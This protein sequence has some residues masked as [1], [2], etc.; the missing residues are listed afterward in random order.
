MSKT[1]EDGHPQHPVPMEALSA[2][3]QSVM[4]GNGGDISSCVHGIVVIV[5]NKCKGIF[6]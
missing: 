4:D 3:G 6:L 2:A 5:H 1:V